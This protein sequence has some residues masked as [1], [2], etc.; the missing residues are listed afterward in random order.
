MRYLLI[1]FIATSAFALTPNPNW[2]YEAGIDTTGD[3]LV[4]EGQIT[5]VPANGAVGVAVDAPVIIATPQLCTVDNPLGWYDFTT[6]ARYF[7]QGQLVNPSDS[8]SVGAWSSFGGA[9]RFDVTPDLASN[10][11]GG[12]GSLRDT[13]GFCAAYFDS[14]PAQSFPVDTFYL[15][16]VASSF[17]SYQDN[18]EWL[19][20]CGDDCDSCGFIIYCDPP[21]TPTLYDTLT[22]QRAQDWPPYYEV[23]WFIRQLTVTGLMYD[24]LI[25]RTVGD[26]KLFITKR[27]GTDFGLFS[28]TEFEITGYRSPGMDV[29]CSNSTSPVVLANDTTAVE[30][31]NRHFTYDWTV[32]A[33]DMDSLKFWGLTEDSTS[34]DTITVYRKYR[35][36]F[37]FRR[38]R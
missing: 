13:V 6:G 15:S 12:V 16:V 34:S 19:Y 29:Y 3:T 8:I 5:T 2:T 17:P 35:Q 20:P 33:G 32:A 9:G 23:H 28:S 10:P 1:I 31:A 37:G 14:V 21:A 18:V 4:S 22:I 11:S 25:Y 30:L 7:L 26:N 36:L 24:T 38:S 27:Y